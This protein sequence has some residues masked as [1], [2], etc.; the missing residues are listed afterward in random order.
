MI[1]QDAQDVY[2]MLYDDISVYGRE[3]EREKKRDMELWAQFPALTRYREFLKGQVEERLK[4][5]AGGAQYA[6]TWH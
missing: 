2:C 4:E 5:K 3:R 1:D 6:L